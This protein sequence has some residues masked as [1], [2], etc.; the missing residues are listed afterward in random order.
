MF[1]ILCQKP[2]TR[3]TNCNSVIGQCKIE[4]RDAM[5]QTHKKSGFS[6]TSQHS[7]T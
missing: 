5:S 4:T 6:I 1:P 7:S 2:W 3:C